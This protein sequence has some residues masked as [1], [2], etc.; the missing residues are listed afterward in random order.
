[1]DGSDSQI[2]PF[3]RVGPARGHR[4]PLAISVAVG[5]FVAAFVA[6]FLLRS[7]SDDALALSFSPGQTLRFHQ[8]IV[9]HMSIRVD[10]ETIPVRG[11]LSQDVEWRVLSVDDEG[12]ATV[13]V[14][15]SN[16]TV[17][18][19]SESQPL[20]PQQTTLTLTSD[21]R[22]VSQSGTTIF[23]SQAGGAAMDAA[24]PVTA[25]LP[26]AL[27]AEPGDTW[28]REVSETIFGQPITYTASGSYMK[29]QRMGS[30]EAAVIRTRA[31]IPMNF[32]IKASDLGALLPVGSTGASASGATFTYSGRVTTNTTSWIDPVAK[33]LLKTTGV[34]RL[35]IGL[36]VSGNASS[37]IPPGTEIELTG[38]M[39]MTLVRR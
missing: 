14:S 36:A 19:D 23:S 32:S 37:G 15:T 10:P 1:M 12:T 38:S 6:S 39:S 28:Q 3:E 17:T 22:L 35:S 21:G 33:E 4:R 13:D 30:V 29:D 34:G 26:G 24:S 31:T 25:I 27:D 18:Q 9:M 5:I 7:S 20:P 11:T 8:T 16:A 2:D